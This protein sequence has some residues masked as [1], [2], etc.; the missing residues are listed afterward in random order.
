MV[1][2]QR[3]TYEKIKE[4]RRCEGKCDEEKVRMSVGESYKGEVLN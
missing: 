3:K 1:Q 2:I 4:D